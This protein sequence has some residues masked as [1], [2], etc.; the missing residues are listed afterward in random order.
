MT[1]DTWCLDK[2]LQQIL[3]DL[4]EPLT[5]SMQQPI[6]YNLVFKLEMHK[7]NVKM[8]EFPNFYHNYYVFLVVTKRPT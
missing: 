8:I 7:T 4:A 1:L 2:W 5:L 3:Y 6:K